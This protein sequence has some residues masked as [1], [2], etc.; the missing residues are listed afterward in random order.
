YSAQEAAL[1]AYANATN[2][3][4]TSECVTGIVRPHILRHAIHIEDNICR[5]SSHGYVMEVRI[6]YG[7]IS[8][9]YNRGANLREKQPAI[10][11]DTK[12]VSAIGTP[13]DA[14]RL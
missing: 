1:M 12:N 10:V 5:R 4:F 8:R 2:C 13:K 14:G 7:K 6:G 11:P 3:H 9:I